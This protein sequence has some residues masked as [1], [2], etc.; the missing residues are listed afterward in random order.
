METNVLVANEIVE[1]GRAVINYD[2]HGRALDAEFIPTIVVNLK[3]SILMQLA[4]VKGGNQENAINNA[5]LILG[6]W[7][8]K[9]N[10]IELANRD[11]YHIVTEIVH[12]DKYSDGTVKRCEV[13]FVFEKRSV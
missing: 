6:S 7:F 1:I 13:R 11:E 9:S 10:E 2:S 5:N 4:S 12:C 3:P 8:E